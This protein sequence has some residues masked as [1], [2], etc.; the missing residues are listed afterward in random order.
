MYYVIRPWSGW[1]ETFDT[2]EAALK[3]AAEI[4]E[5]DEE[6]LRSLHNYHNPEHLVEEVWESLEEMYQ[7][8]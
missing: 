5:N 3:R 4:I 2:E 8:I 1:Q 6:S 7:Y